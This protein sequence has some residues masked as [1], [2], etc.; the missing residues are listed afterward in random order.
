MA[1]KSTWAARSSGVSSSSGST[2]LFGTVSPVPSP[3]SGVGVFFF[4]T[5]PSAELP[6]PTTSLGLS[7][8]SGAFLLASV[9]ASCSA[10]RRRS[11]TPS[12][13][14]SGN[15]GGSPTLAPGPRAPN[16]R[17]AVMS[18]SVSRASTVLR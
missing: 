12:L 9:F 5:W 4:E 3:A 8:F 7:G 6:T 11:A 13:S 15:T 18:G 14:V 17:S 16:G 10:A 2:P 1:V